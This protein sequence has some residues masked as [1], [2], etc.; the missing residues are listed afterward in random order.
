MH[1][2]V[3]FVNKMLYNEITIINPDQIRLEM[4]GFTYLFAINNNLY[5]IHIIKIK[6]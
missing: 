6:L 5:A 3:L 4:V 2:N 1:S